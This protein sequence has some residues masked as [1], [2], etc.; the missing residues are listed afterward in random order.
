MGYYVTLRESDFEIPAENLDAAYEA[1][2]RLNVTH[3]HLKNGGSWG[4]GGQTAKWFSW[5]P[6]NYPE[7]CPDA[8]SIF[9]HLGFEVEITES[10]SL[11]LNYYD[12]K[13]GQEELFLEA[14]APYAVDKTGLIWQ[15]E[16]GEMWGQQVV[17]GRLVARNA[18]IV[19]S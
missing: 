8:A 10:G 1:M 19:W 4:G 14:C 9:E 13:I 3:D 6:E 5:M 17:D 7:V 12:S 18:T 15:G 16:D 11:R 2:C